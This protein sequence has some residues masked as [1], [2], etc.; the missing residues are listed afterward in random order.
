VSFSNP[1]E[2][3]GVHDVAPPSLAD[4]PLVEPDPV[5][6]LMLPEPLSGAVV[7]PSELAP[8]DVPEVEEDAPPPD[9]VVPASLA[10]D[11]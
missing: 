4:A 11:D 9:V 6:A 3:A 8:P 7:P 1:S 2:N 5:D 10:P